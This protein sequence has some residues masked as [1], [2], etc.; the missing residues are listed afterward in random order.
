MWLLCELRCEKKNIEIAKTSVSGPGKLG[1]PWRTDRFFLRDIYDVN[2]MDLSDITRDVFQLIASVDAKFD[3]VSWKLQK[4][5]QKY[6]FSL[7]WPIENCDRSNPPRNEVNVVEEERGSR[8]TNKHV[9]KTVTARLE[10]GKPSN[11]TG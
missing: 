9:D 6:N 10:A 3:R 8:Q 2:L 1:G 5:G 4:S 7:V 11:S